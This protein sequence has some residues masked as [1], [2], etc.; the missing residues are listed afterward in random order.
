M[1][2]GPAD[3]PP[4]EPTWFA[5]FDRLLDTCRRTRAALHAVVHDEAR[6]PDLVRDVLAREALAHLEAAL[7]GIVLL[8]RTGQFTGEELRALV[9]RAGIVE[10]PR[11]GSPEA[12]A[13]SAEALHE[14]AALGEHERLRAVDGRVMLAA[15]H[16]RVV[17]S[18]IPSL[19]PDAVSWPRS[20]RSYADIPVPHSGGELLLRTEE[21]ARVVWRVAAGDER[22]DEPLRRTLAFYEAGARLSFRGFRAA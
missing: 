17:L 18:L 6:D 21:L 19:P 20:P 13:A 9:R 3:Q 7:E 16:A 22:R 12:R 10:P 11:Q 4:D 14:R 15:G 1:V 2:D 8:T 5:A